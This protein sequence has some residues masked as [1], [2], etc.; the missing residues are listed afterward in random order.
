MP[1]MSAQLVSKLSNYQGIHR[2]LTQMDGRTKINL[3]CDLLPM[4]FPNSI[5]NLKMNSPFFQECPFSKPKLSLYEKI[6]FEFHFRLQIK[7]KTLEPTGLV[8]S[9]QW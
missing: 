1:Y 4:N 3:K 5:S 2:I 7:F 8:T 9:K 6:I